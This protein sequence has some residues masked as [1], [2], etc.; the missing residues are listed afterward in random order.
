M[1]I[2]TSAPAT[3]RKNNADKLTGKPLS[4]CPADGA[5][6]CPYPFTPAQLKKRLKAMTSMVCADERQ[7]TQEEDRN[8]SEASIKSSRV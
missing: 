7:P 1:P 8:L 4:V 6:W 2:S 5:G 3:R